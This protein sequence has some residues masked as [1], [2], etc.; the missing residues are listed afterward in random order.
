MEVSKEIA[1]K[2]EKLVQNVLGGTRKVNVEEKHI[3]ERAI[4]EDQARLIAQLA[5]YLEGYFSLPQDME[6][7]IEK[8]NYKYSTNIIFLYQPT[9]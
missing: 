3:L 9:F 4:S 2:S 1:E 5:M 8:G 7:A 6:W